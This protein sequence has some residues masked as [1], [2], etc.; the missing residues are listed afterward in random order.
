VKIIFMSQPHL[1]LKSIKNLSNEIKSCGRS[2]E[3]GKSSHF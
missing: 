1:N 2:R 3:D